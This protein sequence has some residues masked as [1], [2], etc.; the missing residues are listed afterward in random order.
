MAY[1]ATGSQFIERGS[2]SIQLMSLRPDSMYIVK[3]IS[4]NKEIGR[5]TGSFLMNIGLN[6][7]V[8]NRTYKSKILLL[9]TEI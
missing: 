8:E 2:K 5:Y 9:E 3:D 1:N 6:W 7:P 4:E